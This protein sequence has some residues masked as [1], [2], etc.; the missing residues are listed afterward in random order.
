MAYDYV[1]LEEDVGSEDAALRPGCEKPNYL[2]RVRRHQAIYMTVLKASKDILLICLSIFAIVA[3]WKALSP[4]STPSPCDCGDSLPPHCTD[5]ELKAEWDKAG[6]GPNG[7]W[8][9]WADANHTRELSMEEVSLL[10]DTPGEY[11]YTTPRWH[12]M[13]CFYYWRKQHRASFTGVTI[14][15]RYKSERHV[16]HCG[17][18]FLH[19]PTGLTYSYV[20]LKSSSP[21]PPEFELRRLKA[22]GIDPFEFDTRAEAP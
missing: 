7:R 3:C 14:E 8:Q 15:G 2:G 1:N 20:T 16:K 22:A 12:L 17:D 13:H 18:M 10:A 11:F 4:E 21:D 19:P 5:P 9:Y 6:D